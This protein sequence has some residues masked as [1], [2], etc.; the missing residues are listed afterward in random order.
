MNNNENFDK[1]LYIRRCHICG[2]VTE[3]DSGCV[4]KCE[5]CGKALA[6]F[7]FFDEK[8]DFDPIFK[9]EAK[10][11]DLEDLR[12]KSGSLYEHMKTQYPPLR[13]IT[14]YW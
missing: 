6:P 14:V 11:I 9:I 8:N 2:S 4:K 12:L 13:G 3:K 7:M 10:T 1:K 5:S